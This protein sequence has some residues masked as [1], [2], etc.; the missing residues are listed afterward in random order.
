MCFIPCHVVLKCP[1][2]S[3]YGIS[4]FVPDTEMIEDLGNTETHRHCTAL[5]NTLLC[6]ALY[7]T[8]PC[9]TLHCTAL[10]CTALVLSTLHLLD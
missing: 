4:V 3:F 1:V 7:N 8:L 5:Y 6:T 2:V 10:D 9:T